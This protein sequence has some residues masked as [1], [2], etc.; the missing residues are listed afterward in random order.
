M[1]SP[2]YLA[3]NPM[4]KVPARHRVGVEDDLVGHGEASLQAKAGMG[5]L[6]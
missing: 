1:K 5:P 2:A 4:G 3:I 6:L